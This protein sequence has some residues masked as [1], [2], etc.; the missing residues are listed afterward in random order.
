MIRRRYDLPLD[1]DGAQR[2]LPLIVALMTYL[3]AFTLLGAGLLGSLA[4]RWT[5][6]VAGAVTVLLPPA[7]DQAV[8]ANEGR[9]LGVR[10]ALLTVPGVTGVELLDAGEVAKRLQPWLGA[11]ASASDLPLPRLL[12]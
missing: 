6:G 9:F 4:W 11:G 8:G 7:T 1:R 3:A 2:L 5:E 12:V 10:D